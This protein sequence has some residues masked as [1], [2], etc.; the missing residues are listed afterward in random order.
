MRIL[1]SSCL[2][3]TANLNKACYHVKQV[4]LINHEKLKTIY[5]SSLKSLFSRKLSRKLNHRNE[6][7]L[8]GLHADE[9]TDTFN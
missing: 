5:L 6:E 9:I 8:F 4:Q 3:S 1:S 7:S 2:N